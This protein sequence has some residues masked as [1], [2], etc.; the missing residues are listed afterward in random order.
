MFAASFAAWGAA[1]GQQRGTR[2]AACLVLRSGTVQGVRYAQSAVQAAQDGQVSEGFGK[3]GER[4]LG[5]R[6]KGLLC[7]KSVTSKDMGQ[8]AAM[9]YVPKHL[10]G[11][12]RCR[13][14]CARRASERGVLWGKASEE[15]TGG[16]GGGVRGPFMGRTMGER[17][18]AVQPKGLGGTPKVRYRLS[19]TGE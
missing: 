18:S 8:G 3:G 7:H 17:C 4:G 16:L 5:R 6:C 9:R 12:P 15:W 2:H 14:G 1:W 19:K 13:K 11:R 10:A